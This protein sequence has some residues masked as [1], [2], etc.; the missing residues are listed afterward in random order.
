ML[1]NIFRILSVFVFGVF[2]AS[3]TNQ[4]KLDAVGEAL[5]GSGSLR[6]KFA[7]QCMNDG[8]LWAASSQAALATLVTTADSRNKRLICDR[9]SS[10]F[11][12]GRLTSRDLQSLSTADPSPNVIRVLR[13][14]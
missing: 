11:A 3:C 10:G 4:E 5:K 6:A 8:N 13:G 2:L 9:L 7:E 1:S 14:K 12:S